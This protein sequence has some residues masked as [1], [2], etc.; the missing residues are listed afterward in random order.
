MRICIVAFSNHLDA[1]LSA[2]NPNLE[3][4]AIIVDSVTSAKSI[5]EKHNLSEKLLYHYH[6]LKECLENSI[7]DYIVMALRFSMFSEIVIKDLY[8][9]NISKTKFINLWDL[10]RPE[11]VCSF[12]LLMS[13]FKENPDKF[14]TF[15]T[16][17]SHLVFGVDIDS[18]S[19]PTINFARGS[20]DLYYD[21]KIAKYAMQFNKGTIKY[22][23]IGL[24]VYSF[25]W[26][27]SQ[28]YRESWRLL[29]YYLFFKD[30]H[31]N[32]L[33]KEKY[34]SL[35]RE[36]FLKNDYILTKT[37]YLS[38]VYHERTAVKIGMPE[39]LRTRKFFDMWNK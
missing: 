10:D 15:I 20:Q 21:Y 25:N 32:W 37:V 14:K 7:Y 17:D 30:L 24:S 13:Y 36:E 5:V 6:D 38:N 39:Q 1:C 2:L 31:N 29:Q 28:S 4:A 8:S 26:D 11:H 34:G 16:G 3:I 9:L 22:A 23:I 33:S 35:F 27:V 12:T 19:L 18:F